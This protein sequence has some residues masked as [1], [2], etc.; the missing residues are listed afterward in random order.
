MQDMVPAIGLDRIS[1]DAAVTVQLAGD[2]VVPVLIVCVMEAGES[3]EGGQGS[4]RSTNVE[5]TKILFNGDGPA[6]TPSARLLA[7]V[8]DCGTT[9]DKMT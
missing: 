2:M 8:S 1:L 7:Q 9:G 6:L 4:G 5:P 3:Y